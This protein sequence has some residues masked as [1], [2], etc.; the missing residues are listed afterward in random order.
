MKEI[1]VTELKLK[2]DAKEDFQLIDIREPY[3]YEICNIGGE[4]IPMAEVITQSDQISKTKPVIIHCR[5]GKRS[6]AMIDTLE[7]VGGFTNLWN[8]KGGILAYAQ[9]I[10]QSLEQY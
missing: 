9:E 4:L 2:M 3:E 5:S 1:S 7:R 8:L 10:D 6:A